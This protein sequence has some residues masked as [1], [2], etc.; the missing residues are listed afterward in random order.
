MADILMPR[1][2]DTMEEGTISAWQ[3]KVGDEIHAGDILVEIETDKALMDHQAYEDG[4]LTEILVAEGEVAPIGTPIARVRVAGEPE[5]PAPAPAVEPAPAPA[6]AVEPTPT[7][8]PAPAR[9]AEPTP[10]PTPTPTRVDHG[11]IQVETPVD[12]VIANDQ[13]GRGRG[14]GRILSSPLAR[15]D[16]REYGI[17]LATING[18]GPGGRIIRAD[19]ESARHELDIAAAAA[20]TAQPAAAQPGAPATAPVAA[21]SVAAVPLSAVEVGAD[22]ESTPLS[23]VRKTIARRL[24][25]SMQSAP[26]FYVTKTV[27]ADPLM[28]LR[29]DLN[30]RLVAAERAKVSVNDIVIRAAAVVLRDHLVVNSSFA[31]DS[32]VRHNRIHVGMAVATESGLLVPVIRDTDRKSLTQIAAESRDLAAR[33]RDRKLG[34]DEMTGSTFTVSNLGMY[35]IDHFTAVINP[36][37]AAILAVGAV[38]SE[39]G[40]RAG[41]LAVV[42]RMTFTLSCD[43]RVVDGAMAAEFVRDLSTVLEDPWLA[44]A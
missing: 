41:E 10:T 14:N 20:P 23:S 37:E 30:E 2:S 42:K 4:V 8:E 21:A 33:A 5:T 11:Q 27:D 15:R 18:S 44:V 32:I 17:D 26:H 12:H 22:D 29:T 3:K 40:V 24:T 35:G 43:H 36:P 7:A 31:G 16:A 13:R 39:A 38:Q 9:T 19:V 1:L 25:E 6:P 34:L 28:T